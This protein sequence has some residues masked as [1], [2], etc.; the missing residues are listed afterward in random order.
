MTKEEFMSVMETAMEMYK[1]GRYAEATA[2]FNHALSNTALS[3]DERTQVTAHWQKYTAVID[4]MEA[5]LFEQDRLRNIA[6]AKA[7]QSEPQRQVEE[8]K[9][10]LEITSSSPKSMNIRIL[11]VISLC[12]GLIIIGMGVYMIL[13]PNTQTVAQ[14][15]DRPVSN[16][17]IKEPSKTASQ[18]RVEVPMYRAWTETGLQ[19]SPGQTLTITASGRGVWKNI[20]PS[21]PNATPNAFEECSPEGTSPNAIDYHSNIQ[22]YQTSSANKGALIGRIGNGKPF[23]VGENFTKKVTESGVLYLGINDMKPEID[24]SAWT[25]NSGGFQAQVRIK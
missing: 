22:K 10:G 23:K 16:V 24:P 5:E 4:K 11:F 9:T 13:N 19:V 20:S 25:D 12:I 2:S 7:K 21:N 15:D 6:S 18:T 8:S 14:T 17:D 3:T 1:D